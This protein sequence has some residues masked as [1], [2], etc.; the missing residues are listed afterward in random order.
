MGAASAAWDES[1]HFRGYHGRF[2]S[3]SD[4][5]D[6]GGTRAA[7]A[8]QP[9]SGASAQARMRKERVPQT[10]RKKLA[11]R[12]RVARGD[13][14][15]W[16]EELDVTWASPRKIAEQRAKTGDALVPRSEIARRER[17]YRRGLDR[18]TPRSGIKRTFT[19]KVK[20][21]RGNYRAIAAA[22]GHFLERRV[23]RSFDWSRPGGAQRSRTAPAADSHVEKRP[24]P[25]FHPVLTSDTR[26]REIA[27]EMGLALPKRAGRNQILKLIQEAS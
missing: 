20:V 15:G 16:S 10:V 4:R 9:K 19:G 17:T 3:G 7:N 13:K 23:R 6:A 5:S 2:A 8:F 22:D 12:D 14:V 25:A 11:T 26:L 27:H 1:K 18:L 24:A 21:E